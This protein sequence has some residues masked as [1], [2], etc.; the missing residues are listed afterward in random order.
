MIATS[1]GIAGTA[2]WTICLPIDT[3]KSIVQAGGG[4]NAFKVALQVIKSNG[5]KG[6]Y[7]GFTPSILRAFPTYSA[8]FLAFEFATNVL[9]PEAAKGGS[10]E[11]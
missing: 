6:L 2:Y 3:V 1:G 9:D 10:L 11:H 8:T 7:R 5:I 4:D